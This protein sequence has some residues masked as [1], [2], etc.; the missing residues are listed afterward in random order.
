MT[1]YEPDTTPPSNIQF[2]VL[3]IDAGILQIRTQESLSINV[4]IQGITLQQY[5]SGRE[6]YTLI[7]RE[8]SYVDELDKREV[9]III[10]DEDL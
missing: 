6:N 8:I 3:D 1:T 2:T 7:N 5:K 10:S 9:R 4:N